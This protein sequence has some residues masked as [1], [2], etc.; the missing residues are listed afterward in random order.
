M[1]K[2]LFLALILSLIASTAWAQNVTCP[3]RALGDNS[4]ACASTSFVQQAIN[5]ND[6]VYSVLDSRW[7]STTTGQGGDDSTAINQC[8]TYATQNGGGTCYFPPPLSG[9]YNVCAAPVTIPDGALPSPITLEMSASTGYDIRILPGCASPPEAVVVDNS[10]YSS[11]SKTKTTSQATGTGTTLTFA[12]TTGIT[13]GMLVFDAITAVIPNA[14]YVSQTTPTTVTISKAVTGGG[15]G[16]GDTIVFQPPT[17]RERARLGLVN[18]RM[19][20]R[21]LTDDLHVYYDVG[22]WA[23]GS[24]FAN[25]KA[26][27]ANIHIYAGYENSFDATNTARNINDATAGIDCYHSPADLPAFNFLTEGTD[28]HISMVAVNAEFAQFAALGGGNNFIGSHGWGYGYID[29]TGA[30]DGQPELRAAYGYYSVGGQNFT[31]VRSDDPV[32]AWFRITRPP[33]ADVGG[34]TITSALAT[35]SSAGTGGTPGFQLLTGTGGTGTKATYMVYVLPDGTVGGPALPVGLGYYSVAPT[36]PDTLSGGGYSGAGRPTITTTMAT[37]ALYGGGGNILGGALAITGLA[38]PGL[39][40]ISLGDFIYTLNV[41][42]VLFGG[43]TASNCIVPDVGINSGNLVQNNFNCAYATPLTEN[44]IQIAGSI[45]SLNLGGAGNTGDTISWSDTSTH[46]IGCGPGAGLCN[47]QA[48][49]GTV[50][51]IN[52]NGLISFK[53]ILVGA[54]LPTISACGTSPPAASAGSSSNGGRFTLGTG[55]PSACTIAFNTAFQNYAY[56][57][58]APATGYTGTYYVSAQSKSAFTVTLGTATNSAQF[59]YS[60]IGN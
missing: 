41:N 21:C 16:N 31:A 7:G 3:T 18:M 25:A 6:I 43:I 15:V 12:N 54:D 27:G 40:G 38:T 34:A 59:N 5:T 56:C 2:R 46:Y 4:N 32:K 45:G 11:N 51:Q 37:G 22:Q 58:V 14:T 48:G 10:H 20:A 23:T 50:A 24:V 36:F 60:C 47:I 35:V 42:G 33:G 57:T 1:F 13:V 55:N 17:D 26:G 30:G 19:D 29:G 52:G 9:H 49:A 53:P 39:A 44:Q 8:I 28:G